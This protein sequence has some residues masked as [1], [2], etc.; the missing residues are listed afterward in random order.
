[1]Y[2]ISSLFRYAFAYDMSGG[3]SDEAF[4]MMSVGENIVYHCGQLLN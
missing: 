1:M 4:R 3:K 2:D